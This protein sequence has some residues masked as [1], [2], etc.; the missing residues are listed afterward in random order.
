MTRA[1]ARG[2]P[3]VSAPM[4][5]SLSVP[6]SDFD[7]IPDGTGD[8]YFDDGGINEHGIVTK[9]YSDLSQPSF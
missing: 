9:F 2:A 1:P 7:E 8:G 3:P 4:K 5:G 6:D